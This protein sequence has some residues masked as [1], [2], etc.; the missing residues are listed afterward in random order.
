MKKL[1][2]LFEKLVGISKRTSEPKIIK[3]LQTLATKIEIHTVNP[4]LDSL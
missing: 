3:E 1:L 4:S 2:E